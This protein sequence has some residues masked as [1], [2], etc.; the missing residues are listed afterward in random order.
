MAL[1]FGKKQNDEPEEGSIEE[2]QAIF[3]S[4]RDKGLVDFD[5]DYLDP[6][7]GDRSLRITDK[8][9]QFNQSENN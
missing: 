7:S 5:D 3:K 6:D 9:Q 1:G 8:G 2:A 4:L